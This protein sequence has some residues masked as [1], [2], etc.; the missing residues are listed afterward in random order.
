MGLKILLVV[1]HSH[2]YIAVLCLLCLLHYLFLIVVFCSLVDPSFIYLLSLCMHYILYV[3]WCCV[4]YVVCCCFVLPLSRYR[5][6]WLNKVCFCSCVFAFFFA[7]IF[8]QQNTPSHKI[9][10]LMT[11]YSC[12]SFYNIQINY[13]ICH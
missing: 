3:V 8:I 6:G 13:I 7:I 1:E 11:K 10:L 12:I 2:Y 4:L 5:Y 9:N